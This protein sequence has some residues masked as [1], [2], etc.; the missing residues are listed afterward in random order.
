MEITK[1][2]IIKCYIS[3]KSKDGKPLITSLGKPFHKIAIQTDKH[4]GYLTH[5]I[6]N[7]DDPTLQC[8][9]GMEAEIIAWQEGD[10]KNFKLPTR[11]DKLEIRVNELEE[12]IK[13][14]DGRHIKEPNEYQEEG[15]NVES[16]ELLPF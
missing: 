5:L 7:Q 4:A 11:L 12:L 9:E 2:K 13:T 15:I 8:K 3:N 16:K 6:F 14:P 1:V 10:Y